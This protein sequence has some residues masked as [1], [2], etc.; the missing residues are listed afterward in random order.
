[1][2]KK[3]KW[4]LSGAILDCTMPDGEGVSFD[5]AELFPNFPEFD[6]VQQQSIAYGVKQGLSDIT[7][8][9][10]DEKL[11][12]TEKVAAMEKRFKMY[13]VDRKWTSG[14]RGG[15]ITKKVSK[16]HLVEVATNAVKS[17]A[18][19]EKEAEKWLETAVKLNIVK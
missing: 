14:K 18:I 4:T 17:G 16:E 7:A 1:M 15:G 10:E 5:L 2:S 6:D 11:T 9:S 12:E 3:S 8:R 19:T 13:T